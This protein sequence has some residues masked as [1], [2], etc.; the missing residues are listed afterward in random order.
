VRIAILGQGSVGRALGARFEEL[1][2]DVVAGTSRDGTYARAAAAGELVVNATAGVASLDALRAAGAENLAG[3]T[4]LDVANRIVR[5]EEGVTIGGSDSSLAEEIQEAFPETR[6]VKALCT[7][8][9]AVMIDPAVVPG[10]HALFAC[11]D[12]PAAKAQIGDLLGELGWPA[13]RILDLGPL[14]AAR[15]MEAYLP[16]WLELMRLVGHP[17]FNIAL[18]AARG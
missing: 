10:D 11:G 4:L 16:L 2:H 8:N 14:R 3:K 9:V 12:D 17:R 6:V 15:A 1:G 7:V 5:S 13:D 18:H